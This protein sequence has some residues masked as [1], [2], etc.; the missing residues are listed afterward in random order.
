LAYDAGDPRRGEGLVRRAL[1]IH[2]LHPQMWETLAYQLERQQRW[3]EAGW[4]FR[5]AFTLD[6][7]RV[8]AASHGIVA[9]LRAGM[10][11]TALAFAAR[12]GAAFPRE[13]AYLAARAEIARAQGKLLET[14]TWRRQVAWADPKVWQYWFLTSQAALEAR[15]CWEARRSLDRATSLA[16]TEPRLAELEQRVAKSG[17]DA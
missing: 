14:M 17:C 5:A 13:P 10:T 8:E 6:S 1:Q 7:L 11:D 12:L 9:F 2:P 3:R 4:A 15:S 16:P